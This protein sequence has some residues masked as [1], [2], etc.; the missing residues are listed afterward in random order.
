MLVLC[1]DKEAAIL[2]DRIGASDHKQLEKTTIVFGPE[3][4]IEQVLEQGEEIE[5]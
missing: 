5:F 4:R 1:N 2:S 3:A